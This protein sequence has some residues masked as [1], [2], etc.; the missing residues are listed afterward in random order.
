MTGKILRLY[1]D[2]NLFIQCRDAKTLDWSALGDFDAIEVVV[3]RPVQKEIDRQKSGG[4]ARLARRARAASGLLREI[5]TNNLAPKTIRESAPHVSV[6]LL[7]HLKPSVDLAGTLHYTEPDDALVGIAHQY[8]ADNPDFEV[9]ALSDDSG[10][11]ASC[12][13]TQTRCIAIP[14]EWLL[15]PEENKAEKELARLRRAEPQFEVA[16]IDGYGNAI[17]SLKLDHVIAPALNESQVHELLAEARAKFPRVTD[18]SGALE[19]TG[20]VDAAALVLSRLTRMHMPPSEEQIARYQKQY[21]TWETKLRSTLQ[22]AHRELARERADLSI[23]FRA[24]NIGSRPATDALVTMEGL[25]PIQ[26]RRPNDD[27]VAVEPPENKL[28]RPPRP[29]QRSDI[30]GLINAMRRSDFGLSHSLATDSAR[31]RPPA[32]REAEWF[33]YKPGPLYAAAASISLSC[34]LWRHGVKAEEFHAE[35]EPGEEGGNK[36][37]VEFRIHA[38]NLTDTVSLKVPVE[39]RPV[40]I[41]TYDECR[42]WI[43]A[44]SFASSD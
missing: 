16:C 17:S 2:T 24:E 5:A 44:M 40:T 29:P 32:P 1:P 39:F 15:P 8:A 19:P 33:Y 34:D 10:V 22:G 21:D 42:S 43:E 11:M 31:F 6:S 14:E 18:F 30:F 13:A 37:A 4:N 7:V 26:L 38:A 20:S 27:E 41:S 25:G 28:P 35:I 23:C 3:S 36:G 9:A 12:A